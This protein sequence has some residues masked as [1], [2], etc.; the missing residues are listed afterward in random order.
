MSRRWVGTLAIETGGTF[1]DVFMVAPDG[2][3][4]TDKVPSTPAAPEQAA[5]TAFARGL[6]LGKVEPSAVTRVLH[7]ST[8]AVNALIERRGA[9]PALIATRGFSRHVVYWPSGKDTYL[10]HV[11]SKAVAVY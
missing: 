1:T 3:I 5:A 6:A 2:A 9:C 4:F 10:R 8:V 11:L 7:G